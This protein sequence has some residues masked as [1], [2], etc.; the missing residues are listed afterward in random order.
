MALIVDKLVKHF[1]KAIA[2]G[3]FENLT[4]RGHRHVAEAFVRL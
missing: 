2:Y 4:G 1:G 3:V